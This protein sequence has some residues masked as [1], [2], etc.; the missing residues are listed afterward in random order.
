M[1]KPTIIKTA[2]E[3]ILC[4]VSPIPIGLTPGFLSKA[5]SRLAS[6]GPALMGSTND[7]HILLATEASEV[8]RFLDAPL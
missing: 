4:A 8:Q 3:M 2:L 1:S 6:R 5:I 7:E